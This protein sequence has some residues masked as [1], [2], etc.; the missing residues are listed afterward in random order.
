[1]QIKEKMAWSYKDSNFKNK[2]KETRGLTNSNENFKSTD[3]KSHCCE[4]KG[5]K[6]ANFFMFM[7]F[8]RETK[9]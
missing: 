6:I 4:K 9:F 5:H 8:S 2:I 7:A 3:M 1:M